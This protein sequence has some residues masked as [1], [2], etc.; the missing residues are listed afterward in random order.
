MHLAHYVGQHRAIPHVRI[1][2][3]KR[4]WLGMNVSQLHSHPFGYRPFLAAGV[5]KKQVFLPV[6]VEPELSLFGL[7]PLDLMLFWIFKGVG[8]LSLELL[9]RGCSTGFNQSWCNL[10]QCDVGLF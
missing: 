3:P 5:D 4:G 9:N 8:L 1:E 7:L 2:N 10:G 6:F